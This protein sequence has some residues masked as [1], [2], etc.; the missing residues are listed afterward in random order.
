MTY[1]DPEIYNDL[2]R[3]YGSMTRHVIRLLYMPCRRYYIR[4]NTLRIEPGDLIDLLR[5]KYG[6]KAYQDRYVPE[7]IYINIEGPFK[8]PL[9]DKRIVVD[10]PAAESIMLGANVYAPGVMEVDDFRKGDEVNVVA[11]NG[12][13]VAL[14]IAKVDSRHA[15]RLDRGLVAET[16]ISEYKAPPISELDEYH[17]GLFY[18]QSLPAMIVSRILEPRPGELILD[19]CAAPGGKTTH[20][21]QLSRG[22]AKIFSID[23]SYGKALKIIENICRLRLPRNIHIHVGDARYIHEDVP[24]IRADK[25]LIDPPCTALGV[26]PK[27]YIDKTYKD[28]LNN[29]NY[30]IQ[31]IRSACKV[32]KEGGILVYSTCT[33]TFIENELTALK[34]VKELRLRPVEIDVP[35]A[36]KV[37][38]DDI[39]L[40]RFDPLI[41][42]MNGYCIAV[43]KKI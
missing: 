22:L 33:I 26:R 41:N 9:V 34:A 6:I 38:Y 42:D 39:V 32:L 17:E 2:A 37:Y 4:V 14:A 3:V 18:P 16:I 15:R 31:F 13:V 35:Y 30:Q 10:K 40:Y 21:I 12:R 20:M 24:M 19:C 29:H 23:R 25:V 27:V 5:E 8:I 7:A 28:A 11:P 36:K 1:L 43:F